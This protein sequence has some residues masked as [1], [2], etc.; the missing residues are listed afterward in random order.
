MDWAEYFLRH[1]RVV[2]I[3]G[4]VLCHGAAFAGF[5]NLRVGSAEFVPAERLVIELA[6]ILPDLPEP[7]PEPEPRT[8][9]SVAESV[10][11]PV[12]TV[13]A[14]PLQ[15]LTQV[16]PSFTPSDISAIVPRSPRDTTV[17]DRVAN[18]LAR[19]KC[20]R[21]LAQRDSDCEDQ[22]PFDAL[23]EK[24]ELQEAATLAPR[25][26]NGAYAP[27]AFERYMASEGHYNAPEG[28]N[29]SASSQLHLWPDADLFE[30]SMGETAYQAD[31]IRNGKG[32]LDPKL[33]RELRAGR[34]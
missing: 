18:V 32:L 20:R 14:E 9:E 19:S 30:E 2:I 12:E 26:L 17:P 11:Q 29:G 13:P 31:R 27:G 23:A 24:F 22:D 8:E 5:L 21:D 4:I 6:D 16:E 10:P 1:R 28:R 7:E 3:A 15:V 33:E 34:E 25:E